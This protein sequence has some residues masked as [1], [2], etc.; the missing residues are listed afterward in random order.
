MQVQVQHVVI[1]NGQPTG[2]PL[3]AAASASADPNT[4]G[5][6]QLGM[7]RARLVFA[8]LCKCMHCHFRIQ[9]STELGHVI[10]DVPMRTLQ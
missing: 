4:T 5:R 9:P 10:N 3:H 8:S 1:G 6:C 2:S 7:A